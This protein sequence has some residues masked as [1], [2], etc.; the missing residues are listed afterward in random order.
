MDAE[1][2][3]WSTASA[4]GLRGRRATVAAA[5]PDLAEADDTFRTLRAWHFQASFGPLLAEHPD[6]FKQSLADNIRAGERSP[7]PTSP[8]P[9][10]Q[11][12]ALSERMRR[13]LHVARRAGAAGLAGAAVPGRPGVPDRDQRAADG[14]LPRL[15][16]GGVPHHRHRLPG[17]LG[18]GRP[19]P[20]GLPVGMQL[21]A[22]H[23]ADRFLL[24][25]AA[26]LEVAV[27]A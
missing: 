2:A 10:R 13:V 23:G 21:V 5:Y 16:A 12:T 7:A 1:V 9:T 15:D 24:E 27:T 25:V 6:A 26:A 8:A 20:D 14:D 4:R 11:R 3:R 19:D 22:P 18:P 17:D